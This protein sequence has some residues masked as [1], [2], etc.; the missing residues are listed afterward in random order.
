MGFTGFYWVLLA[1]TGF[2]WV[3]PSFIGLYWVLLA[4]T[5]FYWVLRCGCV[6]VS[7]H[8]LPRPF[9]GLIR[10]DWMSFN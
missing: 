6:S 10:F 4:S 1:S 7:F 9:L 5:G 2:Y 3:L 8:G